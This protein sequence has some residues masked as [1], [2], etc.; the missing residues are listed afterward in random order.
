M[1]RTSFASRPTLISL[2]GS[3]YGSGESNTPYT[4]ANIAATA[5]TPS[6]SVRRTAA[7]KTGVRLSDLSACRSQ[8]G[9]V[10][11]VS[12]THHDPMTTAI[13]TLR[14]ISDHPLTKGVASLVVAV[15]FASLPFTIDA[16]RARRSAAPI[17]ITA[18]PVVADSG[19]V[20]PPAPAVGR[21]AA[22]VLGPVSR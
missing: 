16:I 10:D 21:S 18:P 14:A 3:P 2:S 19:L 12:Q 5:P 7:V 11:W 6:V 4:I 13:A 22:A 15:G 9:I 17:V 8:I 20:E 1:R